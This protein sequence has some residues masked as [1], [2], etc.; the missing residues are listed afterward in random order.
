MITISDVINLVTWLVLTLQTKNIGH[1]HLSFLVCVCVCNINPCI[2]IEIC[3]YSC[4]DNIYAICV[5]VK[6]LLFIYIGDMILLNLNGSINTVS[7]IIVKRYINQKWLYT[8][9]FQFSITMTAKFAPPKY[10]SYAM[11]LLRNLN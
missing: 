2:Y 1:Y 11:N 8:L 10:V 5:I 9:N 7:T 3:K 4:I 6:Y